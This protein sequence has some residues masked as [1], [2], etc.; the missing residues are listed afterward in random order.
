[1]CGVPQ[2]QPSAASTI[3]IW[4]ARVQLKIYWNYHLPLVKEETWYFLE[5]RHFT[6]FDFSSAGGL[7]FLL[8]ADLTCIGGDVRK[9]S[10]G[11]NEDFEDLE[12][13]LV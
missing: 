12:N 6:W 9:R 4:P 3:S 10:H 13:I 5:A 1:M 7:Q 2:W 8:W 11:S